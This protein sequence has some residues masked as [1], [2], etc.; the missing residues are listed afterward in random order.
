MVLEPDGSAHQSRNYY[1]SP[2]IPDEDI[3]KLLCEGFASAGEVLIPNP[4]V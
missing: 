1:G 4:F 3:W 2:G